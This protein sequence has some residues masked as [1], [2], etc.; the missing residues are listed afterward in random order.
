M[1]GLRWQ[2]GAWQQ[3]LCHVPLQHPTLR[4]CI[5]LEDGASKTFQ[6]V[7]RCG[8]KPGLGLRPTPTRHAPTHALY[9]L[10]WQLQAPRTGNHVFARLYNQAIPDTWHII[11]NDVSTVFPL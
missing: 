9:S 2:L 10:P 5:G 8:A 3:L 6:G 4:C 11:N 1:G 7:E